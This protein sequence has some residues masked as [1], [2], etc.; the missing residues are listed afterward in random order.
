MI[1]R[2]ARDERR[3]DDLAAHTLR[4][5]LP[6]QRVATRAGFVT[7]LDNTRGLS[8]EPSH[9][10]ADRLGLVWQLPRD[11]YPL[12]ADEHRHVNILLVRV[13]ADVRDSVFHDRLLSRAALTP[14][15]VNPR[16]GGLDHRVECFAAL[17]R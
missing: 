12:M 10:P 3:G 5:Q 14:Q 15:G 11:R 8:L 13:Q 16:L 17:R 9:Q 1:P 6:L 4:R 2:F 7:A